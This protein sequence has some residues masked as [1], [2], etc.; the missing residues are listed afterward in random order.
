VAIGHKPNRYVYD[1]LD[2]DENRLLL[3]FQKH[4]KTKASVFLLVVMLRDH[5]SDLQAATA[6]GTGCMVAPDAER[7]L[8]AKDSTFEV[9]TSNYN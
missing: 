6:A 7:W 5:V 1:Y 9:S 3:M 4:Q 8:A 2:L